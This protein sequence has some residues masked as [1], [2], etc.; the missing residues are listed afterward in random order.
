MMRLVPNGMTLAPNHPKW[1]INRLKIS[2]LNIG[3]IK[4]CSCPISLNRWMAMVMV[5]TATMPTNQLHQ[6]ASASIVSVGRM[7]IP[8]SSDTSSNASV[9]TVNETSV[10]T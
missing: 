7:G 10:D 8:A 5:T 1:S 2:W 6:G 9:E 4:A 3:I